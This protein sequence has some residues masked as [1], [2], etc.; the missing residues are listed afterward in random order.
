MASIKITVDRLQPGLHIKLP[1][2]WNEHPFLF[3]SFKIKSQEQIQL[4]K[5]LGIQHVYINPAQ[6]DT[7][8]LPVN[9]QPE[10]IEE[11]S[12]MESE[13][14]KLWEEKQKRIEKLNAYRRRVLNCEKE[15][16]RSL[17][18]MRAVMNKIRN[19]PEDAIDEASI[20]VEDIVDKLLSEDSVTLHLMNGKSEFEDIYFHSLNVSVIAMMIGKAKGYDAQKIKELA[21]AALFHDI[22]KIKVPT[23]IVR[24]KTTLT[25]PEQNYLKL[26]TKYG[27]DIASHIDSFPESAKRVI[28]Q[29]H[30]LNDGSGYPLGLKEAAIDELSQVITVANV[31]DNLCH[32]NIVAEQKI[33]YIA[34]SYMY[35]HCNHLYSNENLNVLVKFMGVFPPGTVVQL[36]NNMVGLVISVNAS[37]LLYP[38][39]LI[40]DPSVPRTQAPIIDLADRD[41]KIVNAILPHKLPDK[42]RDYLNP[43]SRISYF[44]DSDE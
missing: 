11:S 30:E 10:A 9:T 2:K 15:F 21:F 33:P 19:R 4:I 42:I 34:L 28:E 3:N 39:V 31:F 13:A 18:R 23:A 35:K 37:H 24:K 27:L 14:E 26:H 12:E 7:Q 41:L 38:N 20:L 16:E 29:H 25:E 44:F 22:G 5:H 6:S 17:S 40:Y 36:S 1:V 43:R 8:P 32:P